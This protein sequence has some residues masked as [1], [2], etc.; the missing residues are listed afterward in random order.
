MGR[1]T[2][3]ALGGS[4]SDLHRAQGR[5]EAV[6]VKFLCAL[7]VFLSPCSE[8]GVIVWRRLARQ[9]PDVLA[10]GHGRW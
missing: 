3:T 1:W 10:I 5:P 4:A 8:E 9:A 7:S 6:A 2:G